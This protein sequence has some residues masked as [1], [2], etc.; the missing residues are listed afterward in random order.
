MQ[1]NDFMFF[2]VLLES[3]LKYDVVSCQIEIY[4]I[5]GICLCGCCVDGMLDRDFDICIELDMCIDYKEFFEYLMLV[6][7]VCNDLVCICMLGSCYVVDLIKVDC[8]LYVMYLVFWVV[9]ELC[10]DFDVLY[11]YCVCMNMGILSGVLKV[12]VMQL[13]VDVEGQCCGSYGGVVGYFIVYG[14]LDICIVICFV[15]VENGIVIVQVGV[16]IVLDLVLQF[17]VDEICNKVCVV[18]CVIVI[19]YYVQEIF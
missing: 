16:G 13:I 9:G 3:L 4:F 7:L 6:D 11:V 5:V 2:G 10:Y 12:C 14:D 8:Y 1:D 19:V 15:L 17:E 18:L